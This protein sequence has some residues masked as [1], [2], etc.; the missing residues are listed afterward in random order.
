MNKLLIKE[1]ARR[2]NKIKLIFILIVTIIFSIS[3]FGYSKLDEYVPL[4]DYEYHFSPS[5][6]QY[7]RNLEI[8]HNFS[9]NKGMIV[10]DFE[11]DGAINKTNGFEIGL[12]TIANEII[13]SRERNET[14]EEY[15]DFR[16]YINTGTRENFTWIILGENVS[17]NQDAK[18]IIE[19]KTEM[20]PNC[21]IRLNH[22][23]VKTYGYT[24]MI[25]LDLG[26]KYLC[27]GECIE[28]KQNMRIQYRSTERELILEPILNNYKE[29][30]DYYHS[31]R[32]HVINDIRT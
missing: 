22:A 12:P 30:T 27:T 7:I 8:Y 15:N 21:I 14:I 24:P 10:F 20:N 3:L 19:Y 9:D 32:L 13:I 17:L 28:P 1:D 29:N 18:Y 11:K 6:T 4:K 23:N 5:D 31:A 25:Y 26:K 2:N 16:T